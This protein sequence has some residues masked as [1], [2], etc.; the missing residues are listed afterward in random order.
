MKKI[1]ILFFVLTASTAVFAQKSKAVPPQADSATQAKY[2]CSMHPDV[3]SNKPGK[4]P[5]CNMPL[6][7][8][9]EQMKQQVTH[10]Y[11]C[12]MHPEV[13]SGHNGT[14]ARLIIFIAFVIKGSLLQPAAGDFPNKAVKHVGPGNQSGDCPESC[15]AS[16][17]PGE[18]IGS[19]NPSSRVRSNRIAA[20]LRC[21]R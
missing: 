3:V 5:K 7:S 6:T 4:C 18:T 1:I 9:K 16:V 12:P 17:L 10:T 8:V 21:R 19:L 2:T 11:I 20:G 13:V 15:K 14:S